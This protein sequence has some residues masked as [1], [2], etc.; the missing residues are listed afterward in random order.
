MELVLLSST[1]LSSNEEPSLWTEE[2][3]E[4]LY[5]MNFLYLLTETIRWAEL[6]L[7]LFLACDRQEESVG[8]K[9]WHRMK[10]MWNA[11]TQT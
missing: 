8:T 4:H 5:H 6:F 9:L 2:N 10:M 1:V 11:E 7:T 3:N